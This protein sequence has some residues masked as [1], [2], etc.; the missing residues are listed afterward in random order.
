VDAGDQRTDQADV[1]RAQLRRADVDEVAAR[2]QE[3][4]RAVAA[5][6]GHGSGAGVGVDGFVH[7]GAPS[8]GVDQSS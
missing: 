6:R 2:E 3:V 4:E 5:G 1:G 8:D 7:R